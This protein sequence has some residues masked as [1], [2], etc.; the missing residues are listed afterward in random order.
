MAGFTLI[1]NRYSSSVTPVIGSLDD[2]AFLQ[3]EASRA[4]IVIN[5]TGQ[6]GEA[7]Q[8]LIE[9]LAKNPLN[10]MTKESE[11]PV[12][13]H[14]SGTGNV[15][16]DVLGV[17]SPRV[18]N[19]SSDYDELMRIDESH[20]QVKTDNVVRRV[21]KELN[22]KTLLLSPPTILGR[23]TGPGA[24][25]TVQEL[26]YN[27]I[28]DKGA[29]FLLGKGEN[30][31]STVSVRD[32]GKAILFVVDLVL[33]GSDRLEFGDR[34][35][36]FVEAFELSLMDRAKAV[37]ERLVKEG[38]IESADVRF[39]SEE[40]VVKEHGPLFGYILG[41][42]SRVRADRLKELGWRP[43]DFDWKTLVEEHGGRRC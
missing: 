19:D 12:F 4:S 15:T 36:Y 10:S 34:G 31:W 3:N 23:G 41:S 22:V 27:A 5:G 38:K 32:L 18:W 24:Q 25:E 21:G 42:S 14:I 16:H 11:K 20:T 33:D 1:T 40:D 2:T 17:A 6:N 35:Y 28:I 26:W 43:T 7:V 30:V 37:G 8:A 29:P 9:G 39:L 13:L